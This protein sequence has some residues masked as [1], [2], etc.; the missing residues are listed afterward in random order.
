MSATPSANNAVNTTPK[1]TSSGKRT[2]RCSHCDITAVSTPNAAAPTT[3]DQLPNSRVQ[4]KP[5]AMPGKT[6][7]LIA[8][9]SKLIRRTTRNVPSAAQGTAQPTANHSIATS[10]SAMRVPRQGPTPDPF[11]PGDTFYP[12]ILTTAGLV[13]VRS[14]LCRRHGYPRRR[15]YGKEVCSSLAGRHPYQPTYRI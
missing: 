3:R 8:S 7:W 9:P 10:T 12:N 6:A 13:S 4:K 2:R 14:F 5:R 15:G 11:S 1:L